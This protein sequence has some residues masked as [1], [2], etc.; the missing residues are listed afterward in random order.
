MQYEDVRRGAPAAFEP[1]ELRGHGDIWVAETG[2][3]SD[4]GIPE[5]RGD[6]PATIR[7]GS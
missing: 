2:L 1:R 6:L 5:R 4:G 7:G 3:R